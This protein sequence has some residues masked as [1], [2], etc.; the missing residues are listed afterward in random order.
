[1]EGN[2]SNPL[3]GKVQL[4]REAGTSPARYLIH[5]NRHWFFERSYTLTTT[6]QMKWQFPFSLFHL[7]PNIFAL[8]PNPAL[9]VLFEILVH[10]ITRG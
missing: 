4:A 8:R 9:P 10:H 1:M 7:F 6:T 3:T 2:G 5:F